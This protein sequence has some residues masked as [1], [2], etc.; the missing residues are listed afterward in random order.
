MIIRR[1]LITDIFELSRLWCCMVKEADA[2]LTPNLEM[3]RGY[4]SGL[5][6]YKGYFMFV[7]EEENKLVG[8]IDYSMTP[9]PGK[10]VWVAMIN[11][12]YV[13]DDY[14]SS[15]VGGKLWKTA[16]ESA[17]ENG[18]VEFSSICF[19]EKLDFW[20][21]HEFQAYGHAIRRVV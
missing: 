4:I 3:W 9:E 6:Q 21:K 13:S 15:D 2:S 18:A 5:M 1:G 8:F 16:I 14:R 19:P 7:A 20:R 10:G 12:F 11:Y 17:K